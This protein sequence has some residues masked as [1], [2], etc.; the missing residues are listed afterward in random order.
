MSRPAHRHA[1]RLV[2]IGSSLGAAMGRLR[3]M[4]PDHVAATLTPE[5]IALRVH[6]VQ[7]GETACT[8]CGCVF[9]ARGYPFARGCT[10]CACPLPR[11][12]HTTG[13]TQVLQPTPH[14][15]LRRRGEEVTDW[16]EP[17]GYYCPA[18]LGQQEYGARLRVWQ[19]RVPRR[20][21]G[22]ATSGF[23]ELP[24]HED[25]GQRGAVKGWLS[26]FRRAEAHARRST[27]YVCGPTGVGKS[28]ALA[29]LAHSLVV[30]E[31]WASDLCWVREDELIAAH[32]NQY[33]RG[34]DGDAIAA[35]GRELLRRA[36]DAPLLVLD[37]LFSLRGEP[38]TQAAAREI[39]R[40]LYER[41]EARR[42]TLVGSNEPGQGGS[43]DVVCKLTARTF[44]ERIASRIAGTTE[45][46]C[47]WGEDMRRGAA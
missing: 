4:L 23:A 16:A 12:C 6:G 9:E 35:E 27:L 20:L 8:G 29:R 18:C 41:L 22:F 14:K 13:C 38:Y 5:Q 25:L 17:T 47:A 40:V 45:V 31:S 15:R 11:R 34:D 24:W 39:G 43:L 32:K 33:A 36:T 10:H 19:A 21:Q 2:A 1:D 37:E 44:D 3:G 42:I 7:L 46:V 30:A 28:V 26:R